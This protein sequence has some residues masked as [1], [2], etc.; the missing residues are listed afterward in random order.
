MKY[1]ALWLAILLAA[2]VGMSGC[3][4][5][6]EEGEGVGVVVPTPV[7]P[8]DPTDPIDPT[9]PVAP[10]DPVEFVGTWENK[11]ED[12]DGVPDE[13]D[14]YP[15]IAA[16]QSLP[17]VVEIEPNDNPSIATSVNSFPPF[18]IQGAISNRSDNG[19]LFS[20]KGEKSHFYTLV[21][22]YKNSDFKPNIY[23][24]D[25]QGN[26]LNF[27]EIE[28]DQSLKTIAI[29]VQILED[30]LYHVGINDINFDGR[31]SFTY[32]AQVFEDQ[33]GDAVDDILESAIALNNLTHDT[34][35]D[36]IWDNTEFYYGLSNSLNFDADNDNIPNWLDL[37]AD[38]D[39]ISDKQE[40]AFDSD[41]DGLGNF[42]D[43]DSDGNNIPD[44]VEV[45]ENLDQPIDQD[46]DGIADY[47]D[48]DD[49]ND[50]LLDNYDD[51]RLAA[52]TE[53]MDT[54]ISQPYVTH[55]GIDIKFIRE[56]DTIQF[57]LNQPLPGPQNYMVFKRTKLNPINIPITAYS[58]TFSVVIPD[59]STQ[60]FISDGSYRSNIRNLNIQS[61]GTPVLATNNAYLL[62]EM[63]TVAL[64]GSDF[65]QDMT[66]IAG[67]KALELISSTKTEVTVS[68]PNDLNDGVLQVNNSFGQSNLETYYVI[69][70]IEVVSGS[71]YNVK[72][73]DISLTTL[74]DTQ[75][76]LDASASQ[77]VSHFKNRLTPINSFIHSSDGKKL[78]LS[79][80][81]IPGEAVTYLNLESTVFKHILDY[82]GTKKIKLDELNLFR[83]ESVN[84]PEF[85]TVL[86]HFDELLSSSPLALDGYS[87]ETGEL[88][89]ENSRKI[90]EKYQ[91]SSS[92]SKP[93]V[94]KKTLINKIEL[95]NANS[96]ATGDIKP[97]I[98]DYGTDHFDYSI[99]PT[100]FTDNWLPTD[101][102][103]PDNSAV[104][105]E[106]KNKLQYDGCV[107][108]ENRTK[109]YLSTQIIPLGENNEY[110]ESKLDT[111]LRKH[112]NSGWDGNI[113]GPQSG[114][115][116]GFE[117]WS[118]DQYYNECPYQSCLYQVLSPGVNTPL[119]PSPF[120]FNYN[121]VYDKTNLDA[122]TSLAIRTIIDG[123]LL[124]FVDIILEG[125]N[126]KPPGRGE[127]F[128]KV[129]ITKAI[130]ANS[131]KLLE[132]SEK[133]YRDDDVTIADIENFA[134]EI[135]IEFYRNEVEA[136]YKVDNA[137]K[138]GPITKAVFK[139]LA[140]S[141][142]D[143][144]FLAAEA[145]ARK[146]I[147][148]AGQAEALIKGAKVADILVDQVKTIKDMMFVPVKSDFTVTWGLNI[149]DLD[150]SIMKAEGV[151]KPLTIV[152]SGFGINK[153][154]YW[155]DEQPVTVLKDKNANTG[156]INIFHDNISVAGT[157]LDITVPGSL[158]EKAVGPISVKVEHRGQTA[159][160]PID[161]Q[162]GDG[163]K[164]SRLKQD[165]GQPGDTVIIE[166]IG[167][168]PLKSKNIVTFAGKNNAR[169]TA[170]IVKVEASKLTVTV[171]SGIV[172]G[173]VIVEVN[174]QFSNGLE[175]TVPYL[176]DITFG[177][178]GNFND[179]IFKLVV[180]DKV[181]TDG[182][183]PQR[184]VGPI[185]VPLAAGTHT[186]K[187]V[188]IRAEDE[189]GT[190]YIEFA[191]NVVSVNGDALEGRDLLKD[192]VKTFTVVIG[193]TT[194]KIFQNSEPLLYLQQE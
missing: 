36:D 134:K 129:A 152:G 3:N 60:L 87:V 98:K 79:A 145:A 16:K 63:D 158:L 84:Y 5:E 148:F 69:K 68:I 78:F 27:G 61:K 102:N 133:I 8:V 101:P 34:D 99:S 82:I 119:G 2:S 160:A 154:W 17:Y 94:Q 51:E 1:N 11:D 178:N 30:G 62:K 130:I 50:G 140:V 7:D 42:I 136:F 81:I 169:I 150:P 142:Q 116:L 48:L 138:F 52:I 67:G 173:E 38:G 184:K 80:Y 26:A 32:T 12:G 97:T 127:G 137:G 89:L 132:E 149:V 146:W 193:N 74:S 47:A 35:N 54:M 22:S 180:D 73:D 13:L 153:R 192:S 189:I 171:P 45:G 122:R 115:F 120:S 103:C 91:A 175:F 15:F 111:P 71:Y 167:F 108:L 9:D 121:S 39:G 143:L 166:G 23:F 18:R 77:K 194:Q 25:A 114:T 24:S 165:N 90:Y 162:I 96:Q 151:D 163:L 33:D 139:E 20:F 100:N 57:E 135:V 128:D 123:I 53:D 125:I 28:F 126:Y 113:L 157:R 72:L 46:F 186:V 19:D 112:I 41:G 183:S 29:S 190:Y 21:L 43:D 179:D 93:M 188:G 156:E 104:N 110:D 37:D 177:D 65:T 144:A 161:I 168:E 172:S 187:L 75:Y 66:V 14:D 147:P 164:I 182:S 174:N 131:P 105:N 88:L 124:P 31:E 83:S 170:Y 141:P 95:V 10:T 85:I 76:T 118:K 58:G 107:E 56:G 70:D 59:F 4:S 185:S 109:L 6:L 49:D 92:S 191:G 176:L 117:L 40:S 181:I 159:I 86:N 155:F 106:Q 55:N 64:L 44:R